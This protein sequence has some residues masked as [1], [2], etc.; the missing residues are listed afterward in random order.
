MALTREGGEMTLW[1]GE[2]SLVFITIE[3]SGALT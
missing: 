2:Y 3:I 1:Q